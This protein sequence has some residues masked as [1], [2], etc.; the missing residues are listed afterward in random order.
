MP[1]KV[2]GLTGGIGSGKSAAA[3][4]FAELGVPVIDTDAIAH[5]L[6]GPCGAAMPALVAEFGAEAVRADGGLDRGWMR[7]RV[8]A[9]AV[10]RQ[11][12]ESVLHPLIR[13]QS[14]AG[15]ALRAGRIACW[16][17]PYCSK[18]GIICRCCR[19]LCWWTATSRCN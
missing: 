15:V 14:E 16:W 12:L 4:R 19:V 3:D 13:R 11:R 1:I 6:T 9:D 8:F 10:S 5:E 7:E 18:P 17:C 2:V